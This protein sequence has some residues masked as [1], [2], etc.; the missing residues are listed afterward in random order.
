MLE[1]CMLQQHGKETG[2]RPSRMEKAALNIQKGK[3]PEWSSIELR[4]AAP[5]FHSP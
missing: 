4:N 1:A 3:K 2:L 5:E